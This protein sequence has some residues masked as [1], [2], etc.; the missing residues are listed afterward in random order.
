MLETRN[1]LVAAKPFENLTAKIKV[2]KGFGG[3]EQKME[4][5]STEVVFGASFEKGTFV[6][7][8]KI[9]VD[10]SA[11]SNHVWARRI[12]RVNDTDFI[13]IPIDAIILIEAP[14]GF[15]ADCTNSTK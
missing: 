10:G 4:L 9:W 12:L 7:G 3:I 1:N 13:L 14:D 11:L 5:V 6:Q 2:E 15:A 8:D